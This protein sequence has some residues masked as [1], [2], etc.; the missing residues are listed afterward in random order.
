M[1]F[2]LSILYYTVL[3]Y[4]VKNEQI[5]IVKLLL[6]RPDIDINIISI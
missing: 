6:A 3:H 1:E 5:E 2:Q 4:A